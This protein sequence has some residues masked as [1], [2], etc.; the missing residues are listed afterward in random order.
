MLPA[1]SPFIV[2]SPTLPSHVTGVNLP[3]GGFGNGNTSVY[4]TRTNPTTDRI[5]NMLTHINHT[6]MACMDR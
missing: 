2:A 4:S 5:A 6:S 3:L 1:Y